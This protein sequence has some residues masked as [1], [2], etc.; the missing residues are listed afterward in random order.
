MPFYG[1]L[2]WLNAQNKVQKFLFSSGFDQSPLRK[3]A[4]SL[5]GV[6]IEKIPHFQLNLDKE[7]LVWEGYHFTCSP[8]TEGKEKLLIIQKENVCELLL[9][10]IVNHRTDA[11]QLYD[12]QGRIEFFNHA[13]RGM[14]GISLEDEIRGQHLLD[15]FSVDPQYSTTLT[16][17]ATRKPVAQ[18]YDHYKSTT[19]QD[20]MTINDGW[21]VFRTDGSLLGAVVREQNMGMIKKEMARLQENQQIL[22]RHLRR[23]FSNGTQTRYTFADIIGS[24]DILQTAIQLAKQMALREMN[25]LLQGETGSGKEM[26]AQ[27]IHAFSSRKKEKFLAVNCAA[28]PESLIEAMLFGTSKG[29]FTGSAEQIGLLEAAD[30]GTLFLDEMNSMSLGMQA[31]LL[32]VLE[33]KKVRRLGSTQDVPIDVRI[34]SSC[35][36]DP[37]QLMEQG[38]IRRDLFYRLASVIIEIPPLRERKGDVEQLVNHYLQKHMDEASQP[39]HTI[40]P[41]FWQMLRNH[42]WP[43]NVRELFHILNYALS[44]SRNGILDIGD[45]PTYFLRHQCRIPGKTHSVVS[46]SV[47]EYEY[48]KGLNALM[49]D[50]ERQVLMGAYLHCDCNATKTAELLKISRQN[51]QYYVKK[52][53]LKTQKEK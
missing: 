23:Q 4:E 15:V 16:T 5:V 37:F 53:Q 26:F 51:F 38:K 28:F 12:A 42:N 34:I 10:E 48:G 1:I 19:G 31:K 6:P 24:S 7:S 3:K 46:E 52:Y 33:E 30:H 50:Y 39:I 27:G 40:T 13:A 2:I 41:R 9:A 17:L 20:L 32:R 47:K 22:A 11:L 8:I 36:E 14:M 44:V 49:H 25:I 45:F 29:A 21:P 35:N 43:G 18:R